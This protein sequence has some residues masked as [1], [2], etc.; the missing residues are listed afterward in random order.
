VKKK[1]LG[2]EDDLTRRREGFLLPNCRKG[3]KLERIVLEIHS[4][5]S[6]KGKKGGQNVRKGKNYQ[7]RTTDA[8]MS[9]DLKWLVR[10][11]YLH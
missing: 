6:R 10:L 2:K 5:I 11:G 1:N 8:K 9:G 4:T 3:C 7:T